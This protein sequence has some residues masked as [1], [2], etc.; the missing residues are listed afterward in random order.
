M[1]QKVKISRAK[2]LEAGTRMFVDRLDIGCGRKGSLWRLPHFIG[3]RNRKG[4]AV[5]K[6]NG[7]GVSL[8]HC[9]GMNFR[10]VRYVR[11]VG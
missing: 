1:V 2:C 3:L 8:G 10:Y 11:Y 7:E 9:Q 4:G 6:G 5:I